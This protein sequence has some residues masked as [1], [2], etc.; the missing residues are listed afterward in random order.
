MTEPTQLLP[1][2]VMR[3]DDLAGLP[4]VALPAGY[5]LRTSRAGD[6]AH[7]AR[8]LNASF[9]GARTADDFVATMVQDPAYRP[10]RIF[11]VCDAAGTPCVTAGAYR[12]PRWGADTGYVHYVAA[13]PEHT[14]RKLGLL[15]TLAVLHAFAADGCRD[16]VL[17]TDDFR[18]PAIV[19]YLRLG[20]RPLHTHAS[21]PAR[22]QAIMTALGR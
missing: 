12:R 2:L 22:W 14:G 1:Q 3:R 17:E 21:H 6:G 16:A 13:C 18:L 19:V 4:P 5:T 8:I 11:F 20:F 10:E 9:G 15:V 7:W